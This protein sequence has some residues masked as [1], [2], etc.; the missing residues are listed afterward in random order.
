MKSKRDKFITGFLAGFT[1]G[2]FAYFGY[3]SYQNSS[4]VIPWAVVFSIGPGIIFGALLTLDKS[5]ILD[6]RA[7]PFL[8]PDLDQG[9]SFKLTKSRASPKFLAITSFVLGLLSLLNFSFVF[10][11]AALVTGLFVI[12]KGKKEGLDKKLLVLAVTGIIFAL[13]GTLVYI[14]DVSQTGIFF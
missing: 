2:L 8:N 11:P 10:T 1:I 13:V 9:E 6:T 5:K 4:L 12:I 3:L 7:S 14:L